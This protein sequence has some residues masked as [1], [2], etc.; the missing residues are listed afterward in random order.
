MTV[1]F[2]DKKTEAG[3]QKSVDEFWKVVTPLWFD[4]LE[5][6]IILG[7]FTLVAQET[8]NL[9]VRIVTSVSYFAMFFYLQSLF[10]SIE[11]VGFPRVRSNRLRRILSLV[12]SG[13][14]ALSTYLLLTTLVGQLG[15][16]I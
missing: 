3:W 4:W 11:F 14:L 7:V 15:G 13:V 10:F 1:D 12:T 5:W 2:S 16:Y 8:G 6:V 9:L